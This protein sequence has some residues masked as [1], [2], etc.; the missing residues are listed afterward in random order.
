MFENVWD[1]EER[2]KGSRVSFS[3]QPK[4]SDENG[5]IAGML[6]GQSTAMQEVA[7]LIRQMALY[8]T[9]TVLLQGESGTGKE[10]HAQSTTPGRAVTSL[11][12]P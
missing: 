6:V 11:L 7:S 5:F 9:T 12:S 4:G 8:P 10:R 1:G 3:P 2:V